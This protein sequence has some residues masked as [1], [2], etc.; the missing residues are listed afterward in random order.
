MRIG[1][2]AFIRV[3]SLSD[4]VCFSA[5]SFLLTIILARR[6]SEHELAGYGVGLSI[7]LLL[8]GILRNC[9]IVQNAVLPP[10]IFQRRARGVLG[11]QVVIVLGVLLLELAG[12]GLLHLLFPASATWIVALSA[13]VC[14]LL[15]V[16]LEFD[17][18]VNIKHAQYW[19]PFAASMLFLALN[20]ALF[21]AIPYYG[22]SF[23]FTMGVL[24]GFALLKMGVLAVVIGAPNVRLGW[25]MTKRDMRR[26]IGGAVMYS[27]GTAGF[28][29]GPVFLLGYAAP[30]VQTA[31]FVAMRGLMQPILVLIRSMDLI[32]KNLFHA[33]ARDMKGGYRGLM[34]HQLRL[35][36]GGALFVVLVLAA[37]GPWLVR[38]AYGETYAEFYH[39]FLGWGAIMFFISLL[40]PLETMVVKAKLL[41][42]YN[43]YRIIAG[44]IGLVAAA[45]LCGPFGAM[46]AVSASLIGWVLSVAFALWLTLREPVSAGRAA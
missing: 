44:V 15:Y 23:A 19:N 28:N 24:A 21:F 42:A 2:Q 35:Y 14:T 12:F 29:Y 6:Y 13:L 34:L 4:Q 30:A 38:L 7:A 39:V 36:G 20:G 5:A 31:A 41:K 25:R 11:Q 45:V 40:A 1:H 26:Y 46:G 22:L 16:Q 37:L 43:Y 18:I 8:Q 3:I 32:D 33:K 27:A 17:R 10:A 9:Y